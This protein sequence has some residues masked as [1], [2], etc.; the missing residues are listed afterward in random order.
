MKV[1]SYPGILW[2]FYGI[3]AYG[4]VALS[5]PIWGLVVIA[6]AFFGSREGTSWAI[7]KWF[8]FV[9]W[10]C[11]YKVEFHDSSNYD[12]NKPYLIVSNHQSLLDIPICWHILSGNIRMAAKRSLFFIPIFG[13]I[14]KISEFIPVDRKNSEKS[15]QAALFIREKLQSGLQIWVAPEG[16]RSNQGELK[17]FKS[18]AFAM[19]IEAGVDIQ[20]IVVINAYEAYSKKHIVPRCGGTLKVLALPSISTAN[21]QANDRKELAEKTRETMLKAMEDFKGANV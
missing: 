6:N 5:V 20:P 16:T 12:K 21:L 8:N 7:R 4:C 9:L 1:F 18:G 15:R 10:V 14:M 19:A 2:P 11:L 17:S 13:F 3:F